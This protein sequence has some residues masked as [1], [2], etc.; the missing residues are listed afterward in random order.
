MSDRRSF[1]KSALLASALPLGASAAIN[2][3]ADRKVIS[4]DVLVVGGGCAGSAAAR[5]RNRMLIR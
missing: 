3:K 4:T 5:G 1:L 2:Q